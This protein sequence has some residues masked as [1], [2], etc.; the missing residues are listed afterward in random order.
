MAGHSPLLAREPLRGPTA[1]RQVDLVVVDGAGQLLGRLPSFTVD[2]P[3]WQDLEP[4]I[5]RH[6]D[7]VVLRLLQTSAPAEQHS[8]GRVSYLVEA[9]ARPADLVG[10]T[11]GPEGAPTESDLV[12]LMADH[13]LRMPW[14]RPGGPAADLA[15]AA[16][17]VTLTGPPRQVRSWNL[18]SI[19]ALPTGRGTAWLKCVP[20]FFAHESA[21]IRGLGP[22]V[23]LPKLIASDAGRL[24]MEEMPGRDG[25]G[26]AGPDYEAVISA[27]LELQSGALGSRDL[28]DRLPHWSARSMADRAA[29]LLARQS[30]DPDRARQVAPLHRL[31]S[32]WDGRWAEIAEC[33]VPE[34]VFHG[35]LH[36]GNAR[37]GIEVPVVFDWGD[38]GW[39]HPLLDLAVVSGYHDDEALVAHALSHWLAGWRRLVPGSDPERAW[40]LLRPVARLR[41]ALVFQNFLDNIEPSERIYHQADVPAA[42]LR[43]ADTAAAES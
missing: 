11:Q 8:G 25:Y 35:D 30:V 18:S 32:D 21:A 6:P 42:L 14:A 3:W 27:F 10:L 17:V 4:I 23:H 40:R 28:S 5:D 2:T 39:G 16:E 26:A 41:T 13:P 1:G 22:S 7:L 33:G 20:P 9:E 36:P 43:A 15:W 38:S 12:G 31:L 19:W 29:A 37:T 24:L 34:T